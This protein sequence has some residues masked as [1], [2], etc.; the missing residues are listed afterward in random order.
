MASTIDN[1]LSV[2]ADVQKT[3]AEVQKENKSMAKLIRKLRASQ[4]DPDGE[5][6]KARAKNNGFNIPRK[7]TPEFSSFLKLA[8]EELITRSQVNKKIS[9][10]VNANNLKHPE[11]GR[12]ILI[13]DALRALLN[14][15]EGIQIT[16]LNIQKYLSCHY[17]KDEVAEKPA[18]APKAEKPK[19]VSID[20]KTST[21][22]T[23][24]ETEKPKVKRPEVK[25][26]AKKTA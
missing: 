19:E 4:D 8:P 21:P 13:D 17:I 5:K 12:I 14:P 1:V 7:I 2:L 10:Y 6:A 16:Y 24:S 25:V 22:K 11:N 9:E 20:E 18:K 15:P 23:K 26:V 3:L